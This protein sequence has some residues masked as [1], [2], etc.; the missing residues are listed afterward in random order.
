MKLTEIGDLDLYRAPPQVRMA[1]RKLMPY[2]EEHI[3]SIYDASSGE[4]PEEA[5]NALV[6]VIDYEINEESDEE[7]DVHEKYAH[8]TVKALMLHYGIK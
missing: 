3:L 6:T 2:S 7:E 8:M 1:L 5:V 4:Y